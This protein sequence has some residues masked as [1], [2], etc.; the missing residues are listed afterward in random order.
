M[1]Y[2]LV[3][4]NKSIKYVI[5]EHVV[6]IEST[7]NKFSNLFG[8]VTAGQYDNKEVQVFIR[9]EKSESWREVD[10]RLN[11]DLKTLEV[12]GFLQVRFCL[13]VNINS[14]MPALT[15]SKPNA[16]IN[17]ANIINKLH[18]SDESAL[19]TITVLCIELLLV[20]MIASKII[21]FN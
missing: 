9:R 13:I 2:L 7:A 11:S 18:H 6:N 21:I 19:L 17:T 14:D 15:Q 3:Q 4:V 5:P 10:N 12:F 20:I 8:A 1:L 16:F